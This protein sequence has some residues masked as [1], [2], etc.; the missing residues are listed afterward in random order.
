M[1]IPET[2]R[3]MNSFGDSKEIS[4]ISLVSVFTKDYEKASV[5]LI[6]HDGLRIKQL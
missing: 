6:I 1:K 2:K 5:M 4:E 3:Y